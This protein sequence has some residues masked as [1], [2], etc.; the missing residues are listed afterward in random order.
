[1]PLHRRIVHHISWVAGNTIG[2]AE[3]AGFGDL[4]I[5]MERFHWFLP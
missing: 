3:L 1:M 5:W 2:M 4:V